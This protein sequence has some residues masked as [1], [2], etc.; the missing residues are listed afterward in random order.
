[1]TK[2]IERTNGVNP[3]NSS[4]HLSILTFQLNGQM[5]GL[6]VI[7]VAQIIEIV[8]LT[9]LPQAPLAIQ[10]IINLHGRVV[11]VM[12]LRLRFGLSVKP[13]QLHTPIVLVNLKRQ[14][15]GL[16][17]DRVETVVEISTADLEIGDSIISSAL[18]GLKSGSGQMSYLA[19]VAKVE[20]RLIPIL[21]TEAILSYEEQTQLIEQA[22]L[23]SLENRGIRARYE[24]SSL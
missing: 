14:I 13:Y 11:P 7:E 23:I 21:K 2:D 20:R 1:M 15:L 24:S 9:H 4:S 17:V 5:Y 18:S 3:L 22:S 12:D 8:T 16:I 10:G 6:L 19:G